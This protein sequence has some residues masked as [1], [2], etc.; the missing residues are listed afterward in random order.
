LP[1]DRLAVSTKRVDKG[2]DG[3][4]ETTAL[5]SQVRMLLEEV[6]E[7]I[8]YEK[9]HLRHNESRSYPEAG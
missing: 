8:D 3:R 5:L 6:I 7:H 2:V 1:E 4:D 9:C